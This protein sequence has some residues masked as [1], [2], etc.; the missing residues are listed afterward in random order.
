MKFKL[1]QSWGLIFLVAVTIT[2]LAINYFEYQT[3][4]PQ[5]KKVYFAD[6]MTAAHKTLIARFNK[7]HKGKI[8]VIPIDFPIDFT[9]N[10]KKELLARSLRGHGNGIDI[11][12]VDIIWVQRFAK[13]GEPLDKYF[14]QAEKNSLLNIALNSCY[15]DGEMVATPLDLVEGVMYYRQDLLKK[16]KNGNEII[17][18]IQK[19]ITWSDFIKLK[20]QLNYK[21]PFYVFPAADC[22]GL[23]CNFTGDLLSIRPDYFKQEGFNFETSSAKKSLKLMVDLV[24]KFNLSP[25]VVS[26]FKEIPSYKYFVKKN[27]LFLMGW[28]SYDKDFEE[29]PYDIVKQNNLRKAPL[30]YFKNGKPSTII[31]GWDLMINKFSDKKKEAVEFIKFL[32]SNESQE[33]FYKESAYCPVIKKFYVDSDILKKYQDIK[34]IKKLLKNAVRRPDNVEYTKYSKIMSYFFNEA[35]KKEISVQEALTKCSSDI[36]LGKVI[37][38]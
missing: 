30:P 26:K 4:P 19:G 35:I 36:Q 11:F 17:N 3:K 25:P 24:N 14:T 38:R 34:F 5:V 6:R 16:M 18:K 23:V 20:T 37:L 29:I 22:E 7:L 12:A 33:T 2:Y 28:N 21:N 27:G 15:S 1:K 10:Q 32:L 8:E 9:T 13:W 31:G